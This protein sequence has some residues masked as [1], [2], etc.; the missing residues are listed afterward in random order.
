MPRTTYKTRLETLLAGPMSAGDR[1]F[2]TSLLDFYNRKKRLTT[3]RARCV[4]QLEQRYSAEA[5][6]ALPGASEAIV[7]RL[8]ALSAEVANAGSDWE[9][10]F[11]SSLCEQAQIRDLSDRQIEILEKIESRFTPEAKEQ[12]A[13]WSCKYNAWR[14]PDDGLSPRDRA[15]I[16]AKYYLTTGYFT[17]LAERVINEPDFVP[18]IKAYRKMVE[19]KYAQKII[20][21]ATSEPKYAVGSYVAL[22]STAAMALRRATGDKPCAVLKAN[23]ESPTSPARGA[24]KYLVLPLGLPKPVMVEERHLKRARKV[25]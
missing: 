4:A 12:A 8:N 18:S 7:G 13:S 16:A 3:G 1:R 25:A 14:S 15:V 20:D 5:L 9:R 17:K 24:K 10:E 6:A 19:N 11:V 21:A 23:A 2:A 22:R